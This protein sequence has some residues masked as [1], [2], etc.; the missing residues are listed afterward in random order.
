MGTTFTAENVVA[1]KENFDELKVNQ[2]TLREMLPSIDLYR[3]KL[4]SEGEGT[5]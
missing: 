5:I 2:T 4:L 1:G 3:K